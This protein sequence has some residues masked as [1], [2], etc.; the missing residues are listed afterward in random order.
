MSCFTCQAT[1]FD[2]VSFFPV[3]PFPP[4]SSCGFDIVFFGKKYQPLS[5][6]SL[7]QGNMVLIC[8]LNIIYHFCCSL[9]HKKMHVV[10]QVVEKSRICVHFLAFAGGLHAAAAS[11]EKGGNVI[12]FSADW[13]S[14]V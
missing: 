6:H 9:Q 5:V 13:L 8:F 2:F 4:S 1:V 14:N 11:T 10:S 12:I 7:L 3:P